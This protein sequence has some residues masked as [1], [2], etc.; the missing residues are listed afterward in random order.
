MSALKGALMARAP[1]E[2]SRLVKV[3]GGDPVSVY[4]LC[5]LGDYEATVFS[6]YSHNR[7]FGECLVTGEKSIGLAEGY[8][9][10][11]AMVELG[12]KYAVDLPICRA[13]YN[14]A[15]LG[16]DIKEEVNALF[17]R[18]LKYEFDN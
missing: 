7:M 11:R 9:T 8:Y 14:V 10:V 16:A 6:Q 12:D 2:I 3:M 5:H 4:G 1:R 18:S 15:Y 17:A 13:V